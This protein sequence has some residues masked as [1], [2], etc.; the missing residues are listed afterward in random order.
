MPVWWR[1]FFW[2]CPISWTLYGLITTQFGDV[3][4]RMDTGETV[5][6]F[7][8]SYFGYRDDFKD[9]AAAVVVSFSLIFGSAFAFSIKAFNFQKR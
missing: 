3:N 9:V 4:E 2:I 6:E 7:V 8:R 1:W 5:E